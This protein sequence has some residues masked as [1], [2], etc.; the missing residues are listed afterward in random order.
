MT[1]E[2]LSS[3]NTRC[4]GEECRHRMTRYRTQVGIGDPAAISNSPAV[5]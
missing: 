1:G 5:T 2:D 4:S 3:G